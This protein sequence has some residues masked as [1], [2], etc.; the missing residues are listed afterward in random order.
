M[1]KHFSISFKIQNISYLKIIKDQSI[2]RVC[3]LNFENSFLIN[4]SAIITSFDVQAN[5]FLAIDYT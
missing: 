1:E 4:R 2:L 3:D 5:N